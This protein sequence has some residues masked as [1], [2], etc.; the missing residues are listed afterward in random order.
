MEPREMRERAKSGART[1]KARSLIS[2][3]SILDDLLEEKKRLL[4]V[5]L[6]VLKVDLFYV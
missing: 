6:S 2:R 4:A 1:W 3:G 5:Y